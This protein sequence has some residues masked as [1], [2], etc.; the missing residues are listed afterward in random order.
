MNGMPKKNPFF[1]AVRQK[2]RKKSQGIDKQSDEKMKISNCVFFVFMWFAF[3][4]LFFV[5]GI[6]W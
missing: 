3:T 6:L 5:Y 4:N 1:R 2:D